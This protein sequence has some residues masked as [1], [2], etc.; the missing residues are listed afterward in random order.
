MLLLVADVFLRSLGRRIRELRQ[1]AQMS[2]EDLSNRS[3]V[4]PKYISRVETGVVN[5]SVK[6]LRQLAERGLRVP[7]AALFTTATEVSA[8]VMALPKSE[9]RRAVWLLRAA[10]GRIPE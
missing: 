8:T 9:R 5:P 2:Q 3:G 7:L 1:D 6:V 4:A 10:F